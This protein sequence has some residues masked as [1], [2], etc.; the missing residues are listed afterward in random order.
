[1]SYNIKGHTISGNTISIEASKDDERFG[2]FSQM[3]WSEIHVTIKGMTFDIDDLSDRNKE[4][5]IDQLPSL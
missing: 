3:Y 5:I 1:M 4:F 2:S